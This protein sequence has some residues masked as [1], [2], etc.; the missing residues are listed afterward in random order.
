MNRILFFL[1]ISLF[2]ACSTS[3]NVTQDTQPT[4]SNPENTAQKRNPE[5]KSEEISVKEKT[6]EVIAQQND[7]NQ[8]KVIDSVSTAAAAPTIQDIQET[9]KANDT[10]IVKT[11]HHQS[12]NDLLV[13]HVSKNGIVSYKGFIQDKTLLKSYLRYL[14]QNLP[15][16]SFTKSQ[17]LAYWMNAYNAF[18]I[19]LIID[20]YPLKSIKDIK[21]PW[22]LRFFKLGEKWYTLNDVEHRILRKMGDP[23][24]HFGINC[25]SFSCP[26]LL[27]K[28][29]TSKNV[30]QELEKLAYDFINDPKRNNIDTDKIILSKIF[31]WFAKD[32]KKEG[33][34]ITFL[35]K[36]ATIKINENAK[37]SFMTYDWRLN[38]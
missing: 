23:R 19:K 20:N 2:I 9:K 29:F 34:L 21:D 15:D 26:R 27:N 31:S 4:A 13:K 5:T 33:S 17:K 24:I 12:W 38:E 32:F 3:K 14:A 22:D 30:D 28:A 18:T 6:P 16:E 25:A 7:V 11:I 36:Y 1:W 10:S 8:E 37:K 35:N